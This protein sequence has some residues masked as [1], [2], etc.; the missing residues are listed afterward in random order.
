MVGLSEKA[1]GKRRAVDPHASTAGPSNQDEHAPRQLT[2]R[3][4]EG[5][6]DLNVMMDRADTVR[7]I[8]AKIRRERE[9]LADRK[10]RLIHSGRL[11]A[12][13][14]PLYTWLANQEDKKKPRV[15][16]EEAEKGEAG[17]NAQSMTWLHCALGGKIETGEDNDE[18]LQAAQLQPARGF[19][20]LVSVGFSA[21]DIANF[22]RQFHNQSAT[23]FLDEQHFETEEEYDEYARSLEEQWIDSMDN[24][25]TASLSQSTPTNPSIIK[26]LVIGFFF[27]I[28]PFFF[29][30]KQAP[31][32]F[33][34]D[35]AEYEPP[36]S[37]IF[38]RAMQVGIVIGFIANIMFGMWRYFL[39]Q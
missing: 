8:K 4:N 29:I 16:E 30:R 5:F 13:G 38:P 14:M 24:A 26:G 11:L 34:D 36:E 10:L 25:G 35:G 19:D 28:I 3:F 2:I 12:D 6:P 15:T 20:R 39:E 32:V 18:K 23:N 27:P 37:V 33:W 17:G 9:E 22:R 31:A 21:E 1:K 7:D